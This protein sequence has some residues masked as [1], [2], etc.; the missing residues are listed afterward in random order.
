MVKVKISGGT[1]D[2]GPTI[3][4]VIKDNLRHEA[5][6]LIRKGDSLSRSQINLIKAAAN[7]I[8][9]LSEYIRA[10]DELRKTN[11]ECTIF[12]N[13]Y[14]IDYF[15]LVKL[16]SYL[17]PFSMVID[18]GNWMAAIPGNGD[19]P[20]ISTYS[21]DVVKFVVASLD[22]DYWPEGSRMATGLSTGSKFTVIYDNIEKLVRSEI[23]E[24]PLH[25]VAYG[26]SRRVPFRH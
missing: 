6:V 7:E 10:I 2:V 1:G 14:F 3:V 12:Q 24:L 19:V 18:I 8:S 20:I 13:D 4:E 15:A 21:F 11:L 22:L 16:K 26:I 9:P 17:E 23:T 25:A 5:V